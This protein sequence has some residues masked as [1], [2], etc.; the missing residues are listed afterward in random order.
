MTDLRIW[1]WLLLAFSLAMPAQAGPWIRDAGD[2]YLKLS[3][4]NFKGDQYYRAGVATELES[5]AEAVSLYGEVGLGRPLQLVLLMP[6]QVATNE[7]EGGVRYENH[8]LGDVRLQLDADLDAGFPLALSLELKVPL[9]TPVAEQSLTGD[10]QAWRTNFPDVGDGNVDVTLK[11]QAG[12]SL[13][14]VPGWVTGALGYTKRMGYYVDSLSFAAQLGVWL[15]PEHVHLSV[16]TQ[17][18]INVR[19]DPFPELLAS[20][21]SVSVEGTLG[22]TG[23]PHLEGVSVML[24]WGQVVYARYAAKGSLMS[25]ALAHEW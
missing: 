5:G 23:L 12:T 14:L 8:P 20:R 15:W 2:G 7:T 22:V 1:L 3:A 9:Y 24:G 25:V 10:Q 16:Y 6:Y 18:N 21:E 11:L 19:A 4:S 13:E 17:G